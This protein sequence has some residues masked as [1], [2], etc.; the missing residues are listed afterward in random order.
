MSKE[1]KPQI[2]YFAR[3]GWYEQLGNICDA[4][5]AKKGK[6]PVSVFWKA[7]SLGMGG[8]I[9]ACTK[10]LETFQARRDMQYPASLALIYFLKRAPSVDHDA[11][12][13]LQSELSIAE[14]VAVCFSQSY[15]C[16]ALSKRIMNF[17]IFSVCLQK[18]AGFVLAAR[19]CLYS[20]DYQTAIRLSQRLMPRSGN[21]STPHEIDGVAVEQ[22]ANMA[23][24]EASGDIDW[25]YIQNID[26]VVR[27][28]GDVAD[29]DLLMLQA[30]SRYVLRKKKDTMN[31]FNKVLCCHRCSDYV[32][33][34]YCSTADCYVPMVYSCAD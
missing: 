7:F 27:G 32:D 4:Q 24:M 21:P 1:T 15:C 22:W 2:Y 17:R 16:F 12:S 14:D 11:I 18:D 19:F 26:Q 31:V 9:Q 10:L 25:K 23:M 20:G 34:F 3:K 33:K 28:L 5:I 30:R 29:V 8:S 13:T 6:D